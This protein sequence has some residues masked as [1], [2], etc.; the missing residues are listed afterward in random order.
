MAI[1]IRAA[2]VSEMIRSQ[3]RGYEPDLLPL[4]NPSNSSPYDKDTDGRMARTS[5]MNII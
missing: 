5:K 4:G 2:Q 1:Q 3:I